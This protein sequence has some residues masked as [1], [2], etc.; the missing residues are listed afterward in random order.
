MVFSEFLATVGRN[1]TK[2]SGG[3]SFSSL[4]IVVV[5]LAKFFLAAL[6]I[7]KYLEQRSTIVTTQDLP[8]LP[9]TVSSSQWPI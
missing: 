9:A 5:T 8:V 2:C 6:C 7:I 3:R 4:R 1:R